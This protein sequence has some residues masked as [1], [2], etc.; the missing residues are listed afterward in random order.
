MGKQENQ[1]SKDN[2]PTECLPQWTVIT[3]S[4]HSPL[5]LEILSSLSFPS[6]GKWSFSRFSHLVWKGAVTSYKS[7]PYL[8]IWGEWKTPGWHHSCLTLDDRSGLAPFIQTG[9]T[10]N[11]LPDFFSG[12]QTPG[13]SHFLVMTMGDWRWSCC[14]ILYFLLVGKSCLRK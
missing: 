9:Q 13:V 10:R 4:S 8:M 14:Q 7:Q 6:F 5:L 11:H 2:V 12:K 1:R 3:L